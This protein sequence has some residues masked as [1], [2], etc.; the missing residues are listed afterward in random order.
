M[1]SN[2]GRGYVLRRILRRAVRYGLQTLQASPGFF[3]Q[4]VPVVIEQFGDAYPELVDKQSLVL[5]TI[6][7]EEESFSSLLKRGVV[8]FNSMLEDARLRSKNSNSKPMISGKEAFF[9]YDS[10]GFP[11]DLTQLMAQEKDILVDM[12]GFHQSLEEQRNRSRLALKK[13]NLE[14][15]ENLSLNVDQVAELNRRGIM[16]TDTSLRYQ[17]FSD[18]PVSAQ[19]KAIFTKS[20]FVSNLCSKDY[21]NETF[22]IILDRSP[23]YYESGGQVSDTGS[24]LLNDG[25][26]MVEVLDV[27]SYGGY[28]FHLCSFPDDFY[29]HSNATSPMSLNASSLEENRA[30]HPQVDYLRRKKIVPN[31]T[32]T[33]M[34]NWVLK[35]I[36]GASIE[37]RGSLVNDEKLR[38]DFTY[39]SSLSYETL[40]K[41]EKEM[42]ACIERD[43]KIDCQVVP[44]ESASKISGI[45]AVFGEVYPD[46]VRVV[47]MGPSIANI[48]NDPSH[49]EWKN[50]S[51]EF[52]GGCHLNR[53]SEAQSF[54]IVEEGSI[55]K[56]IRR[57]S[58]LTG[59]AAVE[60]KENSN[61]WEKKFRDILAS[62]KVNESSSKS[63]LPLFDLEDD[64]VSFRETLDHHSTEIGHLTRLRLRNQVDST[65]RD[66][67][68][69]RHSRLQSNFQVK[70]AEF[71]TLVSQSESGSSLILVIPEMGMDGKMMKKSLESI[72]KVC[73]FLL[74]LRSMFYVLCFVFCVLCLVSCVLFP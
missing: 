57:I 41:I 14:G 19:I 68:S 61:L 11:I 36:T 33:H 26:Q 48:L 4:L 20:G 53:T 3:A 16:K 45:Q 9:L 21:G 13:K 43:I 54:V 12:E 67:L 17:N 73:H 22:G 47:S 37:Q 63:I 2:E 34:L 74:V 18:Q 60:M 39:A 38:F 66:L 71:S 27:Q 64:L 56:G 62:S 42:I 70:L 8:Y 52:C 35:H 15:R 69:R 46:P 72:K 55:A 1:P 5:K 10:L 31:H 58:A 7:E 24:L 44:L 29:D 28:V 59:Q 30:V 6:Q 23:F 40:E 65:L 32:M 51:L 50:Y 25:G 49:E